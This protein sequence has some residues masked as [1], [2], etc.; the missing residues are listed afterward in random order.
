M[1]FYKKIKKFQALTFDLDDTLYDNNSHM[2]VAEAAFLHDLYQQ[3]PL[4]RQLDP[5]EWRKHRHAALQ[6]N[7]RLKNDMGELRRQILKGIFASLGFNGSQ[8]QQSINHSFECFYFH[9]SNF[10]VDENIHSLLDQLAQRYPLIAITN[11][12]VDISQIGLA[13]YFSHIL[14]LPMKPNSAMFDASQAALKM[15]PEQ[16]LHI[17]DN[18]HNDIYGAIKAGFQSAWYAHDR[19][20]E[21]KKESMFLLPNI[22][23]NKLNELLEFDSLNFSWYAY[24][25]FKAIKNKHF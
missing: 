17:G 6:N 11:G 1:I 20:M 4:T 18:L 21:T 13:P 14:N 2:P 16:I 10:K 19:A 7:P 3:Y 24:L 9:R 22:Q 23:L 5:N 12:N 25:E 8:L 15:A